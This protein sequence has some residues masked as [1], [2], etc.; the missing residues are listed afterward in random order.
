MVKA[1]RS[2]RQFALLFTPGARSRASSTAK[3]ATSIKSQPVKEGL[4]LQAAT[5]CSGEGEFVDEFEVAA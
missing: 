3:R 5:Q 2:E 1:D 4:D